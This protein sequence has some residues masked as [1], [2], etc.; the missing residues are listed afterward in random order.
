[1]ER[2]DADV[3]I[4][5]GGPA[6]SSL[7]TL[8]AKDGR[9]VLVIEKDV[10]PRHHVGESLTPS[11]GLVL[12]RLGVMDKMDDMGFI[13]K[14]GTGW[15]APRSPLWRF[16]EID[17]FE[18]PL[19][20][21]PRPYTYHV[22]RDAM[23]AMLLRHAHESGAK[24][25]EGVSVA[26][27]LFEGDRA[28]GVRAKVADG[29]E[30]DLY[31]RTVVDASGRRT[32]LA[33][34]LG[35]RRKDEALNQYAIYSWF[36]NVTPPPEHLRNHTLFYFIGLN[37]AWSWHIPL[38]QG[39]TS[40][41][42]VVQKDDFEKSGKSHEEFFMNLV[43]RNRT[44]TEAM[45]DA[46][47]VRPYW[48]EADYSYKVD[49][50]AGNGWLLV[51]DAGRFVD[52]IFSSGVDVVLFSALYAYEAITA[53]LEGGDEA[54]AFA[55]YEARIS[56][57]VGVWYELIR[58]FYQ[59]Q[60]LLSRFALS[61]VWRERIVRTLQGNPYMPETRERARLLLDAMHEVYDKAMS[62]PNNLLRPW[63]MDPG[64]TDRWVP[65]AVSP[66]A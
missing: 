57:G 52:P 4:I 23:D 62:D 1:M 48:I 39:R 18:Y 41:G 29:W 42:V 21:A 19:E 12:E 10:H 51:G 24:V 9:S 7:A 66:Q 40:M 28:V 64:R 2:Y 26:D 15:T 31:A 6:G 11:T 14:L 46:V 37:Q 54:A 53:A 25:L 20:G 45:K 22:E 5:G 16:V 3:I 30:R 44:F 36:E 43:G 34:R 49:R 55:A 8:L 58:T 60:N 63:A 27:V 35:T 47:R 38:R 56:D 61:P 32:L 33:N 65:Q 59:L 13:R 50:L 17:L